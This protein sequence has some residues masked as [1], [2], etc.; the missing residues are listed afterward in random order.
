[1]KRY[2]LAALI[3]LP[4]AVQAQNPTSS[5]SVASSTSGIS[6]NYTCSGTKP[7]GNSFK[8]ASLKITKNND[9]YQSIWTGS[10][11]GRGVGVG[12]AIDDSNNTVVF[13]FKSS[14]GVGLGIYKLQ[15]DG[16]LQC[17]FIFK[18]NPN[19]GKGTCVKSETQSHS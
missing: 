6:G 18:D 19:K 9:I 10:E 16:S 14:K 1:M 13:A 15:S 17:T 4:F 11:T 7:D 2:I 5:M 8:N 3:F 12:A